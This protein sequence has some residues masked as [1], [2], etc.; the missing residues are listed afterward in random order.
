MKG[1]R[2]DAAKRKRKGLRERRRKMIDKELASARIG[3]DTGRLVNSLTYGVD[4]LRS[5]RVPKF[6]GEAPPRAIFEIDRYSLRMGSN[7]N[8]A[9]Y[10]DALRPIFPP[11]FI[12]GQ[13][14]QSLDKIVHRVMQEK[15]NDIMG[16]G[17]GT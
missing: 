14:Q 2:S 10:F 17:R 7:L 6:E 13:R 1:D 16:R 5:V 15:A 11:T 9:G 3:I 8:Y 12:N 4:Q